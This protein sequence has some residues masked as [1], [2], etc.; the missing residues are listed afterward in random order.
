MAQPPGSVDGRFKVTEQGEVAF[1]RYGNPDVARHHLEQLA[2]A[3]AEAPGH[4]APDPAD[5]FQDQIR[6]M[7]EA[8]ATEYRSLVETPG[9][10]SFFTQVTPIRQ[11]ASLP[12]ASRPVSRSSTVEDL[13]SL[14][15]IPWV[16][17]WAQS[18]VN[19]AGWYGLGTGLQAVAGTRGGMARLR[20]M[21]RE[22]P[23]FSTI[24]ENAELSVAKADREIAARYLERGARPE[25]A[26]RILE[27][28]ELTEGMLARVTGHA[29]PLDGRRGLQATI[30]LRAPCV[31]A[32]SFL[33]L[34]FL[35]V[36]G[37][38]AERLVQATVGGVAAGLQNTG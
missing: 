6:A 25:L 21:A 35:G 16:F 20:R 28:L 36:K 8:S 26:S 18:R 2:H 9:F 37:A 13:D 38:R 34:R 10:A 29:R 7:S 17:A 1:A 15:A 24:L 33:Q 11:I 12:L 5:G 3:T 4:D 31:D 22:W 19:L 14:R 27:E 23:F 32:L 30:D